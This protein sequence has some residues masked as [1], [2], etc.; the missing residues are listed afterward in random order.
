MIKELIRKAGHEL[1]R[2]FYKLD[3]YDLKNVVTN[4]KGLK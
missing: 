2:D 1:R 4:L 3:T